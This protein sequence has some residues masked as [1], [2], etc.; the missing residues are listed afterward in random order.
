MASDYYY[1]LYHLKSRALA[2]SYFF[3]H[4]AFWFSSYR[5]SFLLHDGRKSPQRHW[6]RLLTVKEICF[7]PVP[8]PEMPLEKKVPFFTEIIMKAPEQRSTGIYLFWR[9]RKALYSCMVDEVGRIRKSRP[10]YCQFEHCFRSILVPISE[11]FRDAY[12]PI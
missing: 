4:S 2:E 12:D 11:R 6:L 5:A 3:G 10:P 9:L 8:H 7:S 1:G